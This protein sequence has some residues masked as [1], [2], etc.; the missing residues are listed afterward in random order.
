VLNVYRYV[1]NGYRGWVVTV[2]RGGS[3]YVEYFADGRQGPQASF[4]RAV[5]YRDRLLKRVPGF[6]KLKRSYVR[7]TTSEIGVARCIER[8][9]AGR[10]FVRG[11]STWSRSSR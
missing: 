3:H 6:N 2:K 5:A 4:E 9:R 11:S 10:H 8:T 7:N 1:H